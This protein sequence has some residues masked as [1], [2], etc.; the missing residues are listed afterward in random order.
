LEIPKIFKFA[1]KKIVTLKIAVLYFH[2]VF[3]KILRLL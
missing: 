2:H 3:S 1:E